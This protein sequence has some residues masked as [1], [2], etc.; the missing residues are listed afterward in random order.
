[1]KRCIARL[2]SEGMTIRSITSDRHS[3]VRAYLAA[4]KP[5]IQHFFDAWHM[6]KGIGRQIV[7]V[8]NI[9]KHIEHMK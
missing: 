4:E 7:N 2:E 5:E 6:L 3:Q 9:I 1:M 8:K